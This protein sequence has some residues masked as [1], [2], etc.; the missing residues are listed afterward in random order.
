MGYNPFLPIGAEKL[1]LHGAS[2]EQVQTTDICIRDVDKRDLLPDEVRFPINK[3]VLQAFPDDYT[4]P[5]FGYS[6]AW[7]DFLQNQHHYDMPPVEL[8]LVSA[9]VSFSTTSNTIKTPSIPF[10][11]KAPMDTAGCISPA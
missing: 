4:F 6:T 3:A 9:A 8:P 7:G 11:S 2:V 10:D 1:R 5:Q